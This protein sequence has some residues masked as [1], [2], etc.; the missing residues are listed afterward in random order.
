M[1]SFIIHISDSSELDQR[2]AITV[3]DSMDIGQAAQIALDD[4]VE[5]FGENIEFPLFVD[6]HPHA[7][8]TNIEWMHQESEK[9]EDIRLPNNRLK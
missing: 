9:P 5:Q 4:M 1:K 6:I 3:N 8:F 2:T 7:T